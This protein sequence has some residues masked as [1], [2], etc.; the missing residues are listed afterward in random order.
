MRPNIAYVSWV[1]KQI[2]CEQNKALYRAESCGYLLGPDERTEQDQQD[3]V[4][5]HFACSNL[6][7]KSVAEISWMSAVLV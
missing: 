5:K 6:R 3:C 4:Q 2:G 7:P 1:K